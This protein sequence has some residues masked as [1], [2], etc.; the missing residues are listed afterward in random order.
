MRNR[1]DDTI[2]LSETSSVLD[3]GARF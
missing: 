2:S 3:S 1:R